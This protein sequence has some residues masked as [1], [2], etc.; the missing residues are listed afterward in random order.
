LLPER[1]GKSNDQ[2]VGDFSSP[3]PCRL[4]PTRKVTAT[5][6]FSGNYPT[7]ITGKAARKVGGR[8]CFEYSSESLVASSF[9][10]RRQGPIHDP[11]PKQRITIAKVWKSGQIESMRQI[12]D[13]GLRIGD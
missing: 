9:S 11:E 7:G 8:F 3:M 1:Y 5:Q 13:W 10:T 4:K 12:A 2:R 6:G